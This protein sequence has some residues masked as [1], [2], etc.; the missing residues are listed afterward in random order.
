VTSATP[1][2]FRKKAGAGAEMVTFSMLLS[3]A[4]P[5]FTDLDTCT[6]TS[7]PFAPDGVSHGIWNSISVGET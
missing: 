1:E 4:V 7:R 6:G 3:C 2:L 5:P